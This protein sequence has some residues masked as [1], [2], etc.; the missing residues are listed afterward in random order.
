MCSY[1]PQEVQV[2]HT[3]LRDNLTLGEKYD[4]ATLVDMLKKVGLEALQ[5]RAAKNETLLDIV[6]GAKGL[7][8][9]SGERQRL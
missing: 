8:L 6:V 7:K 4:D 2:F 9:S 5:K 3:T 1:V